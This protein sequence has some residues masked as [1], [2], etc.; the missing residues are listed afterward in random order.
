MLVTS[1][2]CWWPI[3]DVGDRLNTKWFYVAMYTINMLSIQLL[4]SVWF[5]WIFWLHFNEWNMVPMFLNQNEFKTSLSHRFKRTRHILVL[6]YIIS[7][8]SQ[9]GSFFTILNTLWVQVL[10]NIKVFK[11]ESV[12]FGSR[13]GTQT[14]P[15]NRFNNL[16]EQLMYWVYCKNG[17]Y[18][19]L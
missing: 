19:H 6:Y 10:I 7:D 4:N 11:L 8:V 17:T 14:A 16:I 2:R 3:Q 15:M 13:F 12:G 9:E 1:L 18:F 5:L